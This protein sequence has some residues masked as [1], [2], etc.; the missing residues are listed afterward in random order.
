MWHF[1]P[2]SPSQP[3][4]LKEFTFMHTRRDFLRNAFALSGAVAIPASVQRAFAIDPTPGSTFLDAEHVVILMQ[5]NR[6]F[7]HVFGTLQGVR[8]FNDPRAMTLEN[9]NRVWLQTNAAGQTY[10]PFRLDIKD[11]KATWMGALPHSR[12]SQVDAWNQGAWDKWLDAKQPHGDYAHIPMTMG[13]YTREDLPFYYA[14]ADAFTVCDQH[15]C[16]VMTSTTPNRMMFWTGSLRE[17]PN[18]ASKANLRNGDY[19]NGGAHWK[20]FPEVLTANKVSWKFYQNEISAIS[21]DGL[22]QDQDAWLSN[23]GCNPLEQFAQYHVELS[24]RYLAS[25][26][27]QITHLQAQIAKIEEQIANPSANPHG[28]HSLQGSL[29]QHRAD[30]LVCQRDLANNPGRFETLTPEQQALHHAAFVTN[31]AHPDFHELEP[32]SFTEDGE[33]RELVVPKGDIL[34]QFREDVRSGNLPAVSWLSAPEKFSDHPTS[35]WFG[36]WYVSEVMDILTQNP[37]VWKKTIFILTYDEN[38]GYFDHVPSYVSPD[39]RDPRTGK[40][41][42]GLESDVEYA[43]RE[44]ELR[45]GVS[46]REART[47][48][49][50]LGFRV[51]MIIA[52]PWSR[53]G[54]VNSEL[55]DHTSTNQFLESFL[56]AKFGRTVREENM[57]AWRRAICG[58]L[59]S[60]FRRYDSSHPPALPFV[61]RNPFVETIQNAKYKELPAGYVRLTEEQIQAVNRST[62]T[63]GSLPMQE[64]GIRPA[65]AVPHEFYAD[66]NVVQR[67]FALNMRAGDAV[68]GARAKGCPFNVYVRNRAQAPTMHAATYS[69]AAGKELS[70]SWPLSSFHNGE[71]NVDVHAPNGFVRT[72][73]GG[74]GDPALSVQCAY[75]S[76]PGR[77]GLSGN[78]VLHLENHSRQ[79]LLVAVTDTTYGAS[80]IHITVTPGT[81]KATQLKLTKNHGWYDFAVTTPAYPGFS[82]RFAGHVDTGNLSYTDPSMAN[83]IA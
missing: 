70:E 15:F 8:G 77:K 11:T 69:V 1:A 37:E 19:S 20:T 53:G 34:H 36:A 81:R 75:E 3:A 39:P 76:A 27:N 6:S 60:A 67:Q 10:A 74:E 17:Q 82:R 48:P 59:T 33:Q 32:L 57:T 7:D 29:A 24:P 2:P 47:G 14:L 35:P 72:F 42:P 51:P 54:Y 22:T 73:N 68:F 26:P 78:I 21:L 46:E 52:S 45:Q 30:L 50:G 63:T 28:T 16:G 64:P 4:A 62:S 83:P 71:Y 44:D 43:Y 5:E 13:H 12:D 40:V 41:S 38:D 61:Q 49:I 25:L 80:P 65:N 56:N 23:F 66:G 58:D 79:S 55:F 31:A 18:A 9:G